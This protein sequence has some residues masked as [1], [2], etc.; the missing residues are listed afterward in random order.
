MAANF[1]NVKPSPYIKKTTSE[2]LRL[3]KS[4]SSIANRKRINKIIKLIRTM[5]SENLDVW[6]ELALEILENGANRRD[7]QSG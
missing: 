4:F 2:V 3:C 5:S 1:S 7:F 6:K